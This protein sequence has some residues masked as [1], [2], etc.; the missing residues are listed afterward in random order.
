MI[1]LIDILKMQGI[2]PKKHKVH[3]A[4]IRPNANPLEA[5]LAG[6]FQQWQEDQTQ[7]NFRCDSVLSLIQMERGG[8]RWLFGG[9]YRILGVENGTDQPW[10]YHTELLKGQDDLIG[11]IVVEHKRVGR[12]SYVWGDKHENDIVVAEVFDAPYT[13]E[14]FPGY[15]AV[16]VN[17]ERLQLIVKKVDRF[18]TDREFRVST[19]F[20]DGGLDPL[21]AR[22]R[23][24]ALNQTCDGDATVSRYGI[25]AN[26]VRD[27][28]READNQIAA[29]SIAEARRLLRRAANSLSAFAELQGKFD[30]MRI[31][32]TARPPAGG[33]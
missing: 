11:R 16:I 17:Y 6:W 5:Y 12:A 3:L 28:I 1:R 30:P 15:N 32:K 20:L 8:K 24:A 21:S 29:G 14:R 2:A 33:D 4:T 13:V 25:W 10:K 7:Q 18:D 27:N 22:L 31:S 26:T 9:V 23:R 19:A